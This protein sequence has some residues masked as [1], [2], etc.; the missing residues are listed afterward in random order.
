MGQMVPPRSVH[1]E[2]FWKNPWN[3]GGLIVVALFSS[4]FLFFILF[5]VV[6]GYVEKSAWKR[7]VYEEE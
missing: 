6:F 2:D 1:N 4:T 5:A 3:V 7:A